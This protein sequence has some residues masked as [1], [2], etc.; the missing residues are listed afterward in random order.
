VPWA[1]LR[2]A[3]RP[4]HRGIGWRSSKARIEYDFAMHISFTRMLPIA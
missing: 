2:V 1:L 4:V 3:D